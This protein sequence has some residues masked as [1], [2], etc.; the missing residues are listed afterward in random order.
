MLLVSEM[1]RV[2]LLVSEMLLVMLLAVPHVSRKRQ[3]DREAFLALVE[4]ARGQL[5]VPEKRLA[6]LLGISQSRLSQLKS[7]VRQVCTAR[8]VLCRPDMSH[9]CVCACVL[10]GIS[11]SLSELWRATSV[12][13]SFPQLRTWMSTLHSHIRCRSCRRRSAGAARF[14]AALSRHVT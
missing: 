2:M 5:D 8:A 1:L 9:V 14:S 11:C 12:T 10:A 7:T 13:N 3:Y 4:A 6:V